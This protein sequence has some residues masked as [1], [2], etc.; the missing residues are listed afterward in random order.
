MSADRGKESDLQEGEAEQY[1][2]QR[3]P[4]EREFSE[5]QEGSE[6]ARKATMIGGLSAGVLIAIIFILFVVVVLGYIIANA[7]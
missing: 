1:D 6:T 4:V 3:S 7:L 2:A 5:E